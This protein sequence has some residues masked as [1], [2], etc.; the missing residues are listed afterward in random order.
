MKIVI[1]PNAFKGSL[2]GVEAAKAI[3][4]GIERVSAHHTI[5]EKPVAD[6]GD[7]LLEIAKGVLETI[8]HETIVNDP[9]F[10]QIKSSFCIMV[11]SN[12]AI[13]EMAQSSGLVLLTE[14][15]K[16]PSLTTTFGTGELIS[17]ALDQ[18]VDKIYVGLGGSAT[19][20][21]GIGAASALGYR[22]L[23]EKGKVL[24]PIGKN[25]LLINEIDASRIDKRLE[26]VEIEGICD[27]TNPLTGNKGASYIYSP[28]KGADEDMVAHLD[29]G[30]KHLA[31]V[32][33]RD[34]GHDVDTVAGAGAAGGVGAGLIA[35]FNA[36]LRKGI[37]VVV[38]LTGLRDAIKGADL[39]FTGEGEIDSQTK[40]D[41]APVGV[42]RIAQEY[43]VPCIC[44]G[45]AIGSGVQDLHEDG[46]SSIFSLC[47]RP[48]SLDTAMENGGDLLT[49]ASEQI[50]RLV[51]ILTN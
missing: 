29:D 35:F 39:V 10:R 45:G 50:M 16:D 33:L 3:R 32:I 25:L 49:D 38:E 22:F 13:I 17:R 41:K 20:D 37:D 27:V 18:S 12:A 4:H 34:L 8:E 51:G 48:L 21:G 1:A 15:E 11:E 42:A 30:L 24:K 2:S 47:N 14:K 6:G 19:C 5:I 43:G 23:D 46:V 7:G 9:L 40:Y 28:Q 26:K 44:I 36:E 31:E